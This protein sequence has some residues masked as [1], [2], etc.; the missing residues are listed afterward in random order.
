MLRLGRDIDELFAS[1][2]RLR[3][4]GKI[5]ARYIVRENGKNDLSILFLFVVPKKFVRPAHERNKI[6]RWLREAIQNSDVL[7]ELAQ[8][9]QENKKQMLIALR[10]ETPPSAR[11]NWNIISDEVGEIGRKLITAQDRIRRD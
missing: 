6:K 7:D 2:K 10:V 9:L 11:M 4:D 8:L 1:G 3:H 5:R